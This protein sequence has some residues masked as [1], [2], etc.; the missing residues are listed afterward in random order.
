MTK[1]LICTFVLCSLCS[2]C[3]G[4][5]WSTLPV[6]LTVPM[7]TSSPGTP[8]T[9][10][11]L[12]AGTVSYDCAI[13]TS[14]NWTSLAGTGNNPPTFLVG[15][16]QAQCSNLGPVAMQ[17]TGGITY[18]ADSLDHNS[19]S[20]NDAYPGA[21]S[22]AVLTFS[23]ALSATQVSGLVCLY[24]GPPAQTDTGN[25]YDRMIFWNGAGHYSV[26]Q[27][28]NANGC[29]PPTG[30]I[31][32]RLEGS[33]GAPHTACIYVLPQQSYWFSF[34][35]NMSN[36]FMQLWV[37]TTE[38]TLIGTASQ[39]VSA[40]GGGGLSAVWF[41]N[42]EIN[43]DPGYFTYFQNMMVNWSTAP[44]PLFWTNGTSGSVQPP[45]NLNAT[46]N[47]TVL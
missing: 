8:L 35:W 17:G 1:I 23:P 29:T 30:Y 37:Y 10:A 2:V 16:N 26:L 46:V 5:T 12:N 41:G 40:T 6:D 19:V 43:S 18:A 28:N 21:G 34:Y 11:I 7:D 39:T 27:F 36:G 13:G 9:T 32:A 4:Q 47:T 44:Q 22:N 33:T 24:I 3:F 25:D 38:G 20:Y 31:G 42:N 14:C 15:P 45:T